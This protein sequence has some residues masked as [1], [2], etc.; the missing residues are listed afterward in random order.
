M[1]L[2]L[3]KPINVFINVVLKN[4]QTGESKVL[5][6][7]I[8]SLN[9]CKETHN[10][11]ASQLIQAI[12]ILK[13]NNAFVYSPGP[14]K[15]QLFVQDIHRVQHE[16]TIFNIAHQRILSVADLTGPFCYGEKN[17]QMII[18]L[19]LEYEL[20]KNKLEYLSTQM[21]KNATIN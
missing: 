9:H 13:A 19:A 16:C 1:S 11:V 2:S 14:V 6:V 7:E 15:P 4:P 12:N 3:V 20:Q 10:S 17:I 8:G 5:Q 18:A 21:K